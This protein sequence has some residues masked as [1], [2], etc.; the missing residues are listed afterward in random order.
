MYNSK[1]SHDMINTYKYNEIAYDSGGPHGRR[2]NLGAILEIRKQ[3]ANVKS[4]WLSALI[5]M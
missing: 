3:E 5:L 1:H 4:V 2:Y